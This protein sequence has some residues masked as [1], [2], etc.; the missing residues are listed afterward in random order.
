M[1]FAALKGST[2]EKG[3]KMKL[4][5]MR[6]AEALPTG[7]AIKSDAERPLTPYGERQARAIAEQVRERGWAID[8]ILSSPLV[9]ARRTAEVFEM[10]LGCPLMT[11]PLLACTGDAPDLAALREIDAGVHNRL[12][13]GHHPDIPMLANS[14]GAPETPFSPGALAVF[15]WREDLARWTYETFMR[16]EDFLF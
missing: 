2:D 4:F 6:H 10:L 11:T 1:I 16:P 15:E 14:L 8:Q 7:G 3:R 12:I 9:R 5:L 13:V